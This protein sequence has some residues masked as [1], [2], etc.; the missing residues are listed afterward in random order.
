MQ[1]YLEWLET[2]LRRFDMAPITSLGGADLIPT[3]AWSSTATGA[4]LEANHYA[5]EYLGTSPQ[6]VRGM[7]F[8][9]FVDP[10]DRLALQSAIAEALESSDTSSLRARLKDHEGV[11][12]WHSINLKK[13][14]TMPGE[15]P[16]IIGVA[17]DTSEQDEARSAIV[18]RNLRLSLAMQA[19]K[20]RIMSLDVTDWCMTL[21]THVQATTPSDPLPRIPYATILKDINDDDIPALDAVLKRMAE[22]LQDRGEFSYR[23]RREDGIHFMKADV[24]LRRTAYGM[25]R[26]IIGS[27]WDVTEYKLLEIALRDADRRKDEFLAML[28]H[29]LRNP[30]APLRTGVALLERGDIDPAATDIVGMMSRQIEHMTHLVGDLLEVSRITQGRI[31]LQRE[32]TEVSTALAR[33]HE[34]VDDMIRGRRQTLTVRGDTSHLTVFVDPNRFAQILINILHNASKY[35]PEGSEIHIRVWA[36]RRA[37]P[38][39]TSY[40]R[41]SSRRAM[42][43]KQAVVIEVADHGSGITAD[44]LPNV[45]DL[46]A[47]GT[48][49]LDRSEGGLGIGLSIV[50]RLV[51]MQ[52]GTISITSPGIG[53]GTTVRL[54]FPRVSPMSKRS[55]AS[56]QPPLP[57]RVP[58]A[59]QSRALRVLIV[60][61]NRDAADSLSMLCEAEHHEPRAVYG[62]ADGIRAA[63][64]FAPEVALLD[65]GLPEMDGYQLARE[66][67]AICPRPPVL[68]AVTGYGQDEDRARS[69]AAGF[70]HHFVKPVD[71]DELL[72]V[73]T[74]LSARASESMPL[75][76]K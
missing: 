6:A 51:D 40:N 25:P 49:T 36:E 75:P 68:I 70:A 18:D 21:E 10:F 63:Q 22:G 5:C 69:K 64:D 50:K 74:S 4:V 29:E 16:N 3:F 62:S 12:R 39:F 1:I 61:D 7:S 52:D 35:S 60:D 20:I 30:L 54:S 66:L 71:I 8:F 19:A 38:K 33:V 34:S 32:E 17:L 28:A 53:A 56:R 2:F 31:V 48:R 55:D 65:I 13:R 44:L 11:F 23:I 26:Y 57:A 46:F 73:L 76:L 59:E 43:P 14:Y 72:A 42:R 9:E 45:F 24:V 41:L 27:L 15:S 37:A 58:D 67:T 47:Q